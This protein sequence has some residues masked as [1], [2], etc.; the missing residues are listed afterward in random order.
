MPTDRIVLTPKGHFSLA[1]SIRF[2]CGFTP[3]SYR[4]EDD[5]TLR[6]AFPVERD[7][8]AVAVSVHQG[9]AGRVTA[10]VAGDVGAGEVRDQLERMLSLDVDASSLPDVV[11]DDRVAAEL[12]RESPGLRPVCFP[13]PYE[14]AAWA[15]LSQRV[16][17]KQAARIRARMCE[18]M[19]TPVEIDGLSIPAFPGPER[20]RRA[21]SIRSVPDAKLDRLHAIAEAALEG[22]L[23][24]AALRAAGP[25]RAI[26]ELQELP[27]IG[28]F[29]ADLVLIR[30]A[31]EPD[32]FSRT[33]R[34][35]QAAMAEAYDVDPD[36]VDAL[37]AIAD[38]WR[39]FRSWI[40]FLFRSRS[41]LAAA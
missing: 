31:G 32:R 28:P 40:G 24:G 7:W 14:A 38:G 6:L 2:L 9:D 30:G 8:G 39:P 23:D 4:G 29:G 20:L 21:S 5:D 12:V 34:R 10:T 15:V 17:M 27:G 26:D 19:G 41:T 37:T 35:L 33:E 13:S 36:D 11:A 25:E 16:Q 1:A 18:E 3:L 22:R